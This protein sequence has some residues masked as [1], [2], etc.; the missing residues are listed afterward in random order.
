MVTE[1]VL[2][3]LIIIVLILINGLFVAAEFAIIGVRPTRI[4]QLVDQGH[5]TARRVQRI[6]EDPVKQDRYIATAQLGITLASLGLGMYGEHVVADWLLGPLHDWIHL[7]EASAHA[8]AA[9]VSL[10]LLTFAHVVVGEMVPKSLALQYADRTALGISG[11]MRVMSILFRPAVLLLNAIGNGLLGLLGIP[12]ADAQQRLYSP[13]E[14]D[15][16]VS[17]SGE[18]GLLSD[19][20]EQLLHNIFDF[21][22]RHVGQVMTPRRRMVA[23]PIGIGKEELQQF[24]TTHP[25]SR[26]PVYDGDLDHVVGLLLLRDLVRQQ[27]QQPD[28]FDLVAL[29]R[30][31]P[32]APE[33]MPVEHL[34][35]VFK[36]THI[37]MARVADEYGGTAG[38]VTLEDLVEEVVGEVRDEFEEGAPPLLREIE[39][40]VLLARGDLL[41]DDLVEDTPVRLPN[42]APDVETVG[43]LVVG[44]LGR[45]PRKNDRVEINGA[46]Y[47]VEQVEG[48]A[49]T[50]VRIVLAQESSDESAKPADAL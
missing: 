28:T 35:A 10:S 34:L 43:G 14:L 21:S 12:A 5:V 17:E 29:L 32:T 9:L 37:H 3:I 1:V 45:P 33:G 15:L 7:D 42:D 26:Y 19:N 6:L 16:V 13:E 8:V 46:T 36:R 49:A 4:R 27:L 22:E 25:F 30:P 41:L 31:I 44:M 40:G 47:T 50:E 23:L 39:P 2:P 18:G 24:V 48:L 20:A 11:I 38:L